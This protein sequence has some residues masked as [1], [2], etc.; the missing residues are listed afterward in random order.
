[1]SWEYV[2]GIV[3]ACAVSGSGWAW[4]GMRR[5]AALERVRVA[6]MFNQALYRYGCLSPTTR[7]IA[8]A[9]DSGAVKLDDP[10]KFG[11][12]VRMRL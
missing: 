3:V 7:W 6:N 12:K 9:V 5:G 11:V 2:L 4:W 1:V 8:N 10:D